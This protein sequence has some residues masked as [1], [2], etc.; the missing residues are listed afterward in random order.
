MDKKKKVLEVTAA[1]LVDLKA[2]LFRK[3]EEFKREKATGGPSKPQ[4]AQ[5]KPNIWSKQN[6]GVNTRAERDVEEKTE[7]DNTLEKS[8]KRL[9]EKALLYEKMTKGDFPDEETEELYLVDFAQK[10]IEKRKE[11][12]TLCEK[13]RMKEEEQEVSTV[14]LPIPDPKDP[15]EEWV[16]YVDSLG[17]S[18]R[19]MEKDLPSLLKMDK[20]LNGKKVDAQAKT[21]LSE[22]MRREI[23]R[24]Q[25]EQEEEEALKRPIGPLHYEDIR[26][27]E[28]RQL[29]VGYFAFARDEL[30]R[31]KQMETLN[32]LR[33]QTEDQRL[34]HERL[35][36]KRKSMLDARLAKL[37]Q[38][39]M[40][41]K[42]IEAEPET[43]QDDEE[44]TVGPQPEEHT[45]HEAKVE[46]VIQERRDTKPGTTHIR[47]WD[48][49]KEFTFG[50]WSKVR[51]DLRNDRDPDFAPPSFYA[52]EQKRTAKSQKRTWSKK[53]PAS[54]KSSGPQRNHYG[55]GHSESSQHSYEHPGSSQ[56]GYR[57]PGSNQYGYGGPAS[58]QYGYGDPPSSQ[59]GYG[60]PASSQHGYGDP[61][62]SQHGY[63]DPASSQHGYGD[64][65]SSQHGYGDPASSQ[66]GYGDPASSQHGYGD[67]ASSQHGY[68]DPASS[69]H[70]YGDPA[71]RQ[72]GY[73]DPASR[74]HGYEELGPTK[75]A[76][77]DEK[78]LDE[79][80]AF[81]RNMT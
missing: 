32:M 41:E 43:A 4:A 79:M 55:Y 33:D 23:Q 80:L 20:N 54:E 67:P 14:P 46:V 21:L 62:S 78:S 5:K 22:D 17:R 57:D 53:G 36:A 12:Q 29:G 34:K 71:S 76:K 70:G 31:K 64:P 2:E 24:Q 59:Y 72:H 25:W 18:R 11:V 73:G 69:Q 45:D 35:K 49:G 39:K 50:R 44:E 27:N 65:A 40:K 28:A 42:G 19:C 75:P 3:Q 1:S 37:R 26:D 8:R 16:D 60:D 9:E 68:G 74:Q 52:S 7:E 13:D 6:A 10:I 15:G 66:H 63:G 48:R 38:R 81:Y 61:A 58:S 77:L 51:D 47:E 56:H 30:S